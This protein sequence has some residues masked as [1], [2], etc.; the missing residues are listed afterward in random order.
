MGEDVQP[1]YAETGHFW[2]N[3]PELYDK[4]YPISTEI[5][6]HE[7]LKYTCL[8]NEHAYKEYGWKPKTLLAEGIR[9]TVEFSCKVLEKA[10]KEK[11]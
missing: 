9:N 11:Q 10:K 1:E 4:P 8:S 7:V 3:Y 6:E 5:M 2:A